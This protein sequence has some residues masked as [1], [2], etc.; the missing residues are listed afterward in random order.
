V[1]GV[2]DWST[3]VDERLSDAAVL[4]VAYLEVERILARARERAERRHLRLVPA[5]T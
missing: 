4:L 3:D 5:D 2:Y 1:T